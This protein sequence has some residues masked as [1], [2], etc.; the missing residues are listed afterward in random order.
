MAA[1]TAKRCLDRDTLLII[2][3]TTS[4]NFTGL[5]SI[6]TLG[7]IDSGGLARGTLLHTALAATTSGQVLG[8]LD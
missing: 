2:Q 8:I 5:R 4:L 1:H 7:P 6:A 3:D